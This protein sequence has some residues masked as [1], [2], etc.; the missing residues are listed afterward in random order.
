MSDIA[1]T[2]FDHYTKYLGNPVLNTTYKAEGFDNSIQV[3]Q[4]EKV[5]RG[6]TTLATIGFNRLKINHKKDFIEIVI[7]V[8]DHIKEAEKFLIDILFSSLSHNYFIEEFISIGSSL[9]FPE[10]ATNNIKKTGLYFTEPMPFP[11][12]FRRINSSSRLIIAIPITSA[13]HEYIKQH[14]GLSF[15]TVLEKKCT[16]PFDV[17]RKSVV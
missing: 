14:G 11:E 2:F 13:E 15:E 7:V 4:F 5:F 16:D 12:G 9:G 3:L 6:C 10:T 17:N 8:D 1:E